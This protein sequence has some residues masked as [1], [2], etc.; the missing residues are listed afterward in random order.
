MS[1]NEEEN[2]VDQFLSDLRGLLL[3]KSYEHTIT[4]SR[5][6]ITRFDDRGHGTNEPTGN[7][8]YTIAFLKG[9]AENERS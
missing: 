4:E 2:R 3:S 1:E 5:P 6:A 9:E 7:I 8:V